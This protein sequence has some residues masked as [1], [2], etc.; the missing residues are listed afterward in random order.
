MGTARTAARSIAAP[1]EDD[2]NNK[3]FD[4]LDL[5]L[6]RPAPSYNFSQHLESDATS[7]P[8][9]SSRV[10]P[11]GIEMP[12]LL[13]GCGIKVEIERDWGRRKRRGK[14]AKVQQ[15]EREKSLGLVFVGLYLSA[16]QRLHFGIHVCVL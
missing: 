15:K 6:W 9:S 12:G 1:R 2:N 8:V 4:D 10:S 5:V 14:R 11:N 3:V 7:S 13:R 16:H